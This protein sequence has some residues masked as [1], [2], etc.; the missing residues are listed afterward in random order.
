MHPDIWGQSHLAALVPCSAACCASIRL[1]RVAAGTGQCRQ[2]CDVC[3]CVHRLDGTQP[4]LFL[5]WT[6]VQNLSGFIANYRLCIL[7][8]G[9]QL[10]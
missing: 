6:I 10:R 5:A 7:T 9:M 2:F 4:L 8:C 3:L 1:V